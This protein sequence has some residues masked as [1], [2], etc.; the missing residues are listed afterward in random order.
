MSSWNIK[1]R[2]LS[3]YGLLQ[4]PL[5]GFHTNQQSNSNGSKYLSGIWLP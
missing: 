2:C 4:S 1:E 5:F 3:S